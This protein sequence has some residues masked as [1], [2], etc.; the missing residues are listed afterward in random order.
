M[1]FSAFEYRKGYD[2]DFNFYA[3]I[4]KGGVNRLSFTAITKKIKKIREATENVFIVISPHWGGTRNYGGK[5]DIQTEMGHKLID[6]GA[7]LIIG[8]G[9]HNLQQIEK[10]KGH[11]I[12]YS[13]GNFLYNS[14]GNFNKYNAAPY[15]LIVKLVFSENRNE[16]H[17]KSIQDFSYLSNHKIYAIIPNCY[18]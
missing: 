11:W 15:G 3:S 17:N 8:H 2:K 9:P 5:T 1:V 13:L 14:F 4:S 12:I 7:D 18:R 6:A 16:N 10:Y